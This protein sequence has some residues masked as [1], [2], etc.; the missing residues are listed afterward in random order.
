MIRFSHVG[1]R[2]GSGTLALNDVT[3]HL[4][5][6]SLTFLTGHSG[7]GKS[8]LMRLV[9]LIERASRG[10]VIVGGI[11]LGKLSSRGVPAFRRGI[12]A[13]FQ[14]NKLI[15][16][17][18]VGHN[19]ALPLIVAGVPH[20]EVG[21][22]VRA[23]LDKVGLLAKERAMPETLSTGERQRACIARAVINTPNVLL[24][25]EPTGNLDES[26]ARQVMALFREFNRHRVTVLIA[27]HNPRLM[28]EF[29]RYRRLELNQG[30]LVRDDGHD[31]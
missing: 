22:R 21:R 14:D 26:M 19:V 5:P 20:R 23:S 17:R 18:T 15:A 9:L 10:Q 16:D 24:A 27:T 31:A 12:G 8:T 3:F 29:P 30:R 11:N 1:K 2:Y 6:E 7:A 13:V 25:D 4:E 28:D